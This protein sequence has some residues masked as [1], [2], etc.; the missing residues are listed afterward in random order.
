MNCSIGQV[1]KMMKVM[2]ENI[3]VEKLSD[4]YKA[5]DPESLLLEWSKDYSKKEITSYTCYSLDNISVIE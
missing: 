4:G 1:S 3:W 2:V 5:I